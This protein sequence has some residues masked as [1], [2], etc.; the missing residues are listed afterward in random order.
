[1]GWNAGVYLFGPGFAIHGWWV[2]VAFG[3]VGIVIAT[4]NWLRRWYLPVIPRLR[5][6]DPSFIAGGQAGIG[7]ASLIFSAAGLVPARSRWHLALTVAGFVCF[8]VGGIGTWAYGAFFV[9]D[10]DRTG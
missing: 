3:A 9:P 2:G 8:G 5:G 7:I 10:P 1:M 6:I 4:G